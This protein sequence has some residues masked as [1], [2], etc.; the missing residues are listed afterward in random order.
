MPTYRAPVDNVLFL[1]TDVLGF[2]RHANLPGF[3]DATPETVETI[4]KEGARFAEEVLTPLNRVGDVEGCTRHD[5][6]SVTTPAGFREAYRDYAAGGWVGLAGDADYGGQGLPYV[7]AAAMNEFVTSANMAFG[8]Y[9]GPDARRDRRAHPSRQRRAEEDLPAEAHGRHVDRHHEP[10][11]AAGRHR[12]RAHS[13]PRHAQ[14]R[15]Q[16]RDHRQQDLHLLRRARPRGEHRPPRARPDRRRAGRD[17]GHLALRR[18]EV[19]SRPPTALRARETPSPAARSK[20][21]WAS[22]ATPPAS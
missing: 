19:H 21:R 12:P 2:Y 13:G 6:G 7:L 8:M 18:A 4:L 22:T 20:R 15:R 3:A 1:L 11:R 5:D 10:H 16:L 14:L 17:Q 9:P